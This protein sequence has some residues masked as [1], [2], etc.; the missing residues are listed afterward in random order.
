MIYTLFTL[1]CL[2]VLI[3]LLAIVYISF[4]WF[5]EPLDIFHTVVS[6]TC[7]ISAFMLAVY[8]Y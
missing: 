2:I 8:L 6:A 7:A 4:W 5:D 1:F 3:I